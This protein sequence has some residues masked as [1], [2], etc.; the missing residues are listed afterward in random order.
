LYCKHAGNVIIG[1]ESVV[2]LLLDKLLDAVG[3]WPVPVFAQILLTISCNTGTSSVGFLPAIFKQVKFNPARFGLAL[4]P[5]VI[6]S[7]TFVANLAVTSEI[8][9]PVHK[10]IQAMSGPCHT[11]QLD[12]I[13]SHPFVEALELVGI[14]D[15]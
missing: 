10:S 6:K 3:V 13:L 2:W 15:T 8:V 4:T 14:I 5:F 1:R 7:Q 11:T 9:S 12:D